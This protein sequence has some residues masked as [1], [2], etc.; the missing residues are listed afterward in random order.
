[1]KHRR[2]A[3]LSKKHAHGIALKKIHGQHFLREDRFAWSMLDAVTLTSRTS[4]FEIG[5]GDG[6]LTRIILQSPVARL[7]VFEIDPEWASYVKKNVTDKRLTVFEKDFLTVD[8]TDLARYAPWVVLANLPY[9]ITFPILHKF[10]SIRHLLQEGV[11]MMQEEV[12]QKIVKTRGAGYGFVSL[13]FQYYFDWKLLD[14]VPPQAFQ[15]PPKVYSRLLYF[16]PCVNVTPIPEEEQFWLFIKRCFKQPR[17]TLQN[18]LRQSHYDVAVIPEEVLLQRA[19]QLNMKDFLDL[20]D[21]VRMS[22]KA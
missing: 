15:P 14:K 21:H 20:W 7:W 13:F 2:S 8:E 1:M 11:I 17:R 19:Q 16:K 18:N 6:F 4:V 10:R 5:C 22:L 9:N 3:S 12:A